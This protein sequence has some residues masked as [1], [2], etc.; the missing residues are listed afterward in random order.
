MIVTSFAEQVYHKIWPTGG[1]YEDFPGRLFEV[2]LQGW[3]YEHHF[4]SEP[5]A[6]LKPKLIVEVGV[7]KGASAIYMG[8]EV[9]RLQLDSVIIAVDTWLGSWEHWLQPHWYAEL[10]FRGGYPNLYHKF[11]GNVVANKLTQV[12]VPLPL[13]SANAARVVRAQLPLVDMVHV[14]A[15]HDYDAVSEELRHWWELLQPSG[16][17]I[18]D[19]YVDDGGAFPDVKRAVDGFREQHPTDGFMSSQGKCAFRKC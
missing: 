3:N 5:I 9:K 13:D 16:I 11:I 15:G 1:P 14:D 6:A 17:L 7:W 18:C 12:I 4:L 10:C 8:K 2:D 19:D